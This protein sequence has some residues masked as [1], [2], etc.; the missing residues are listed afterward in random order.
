MCFM[1]IIFNVK[2]L[3]KNKYILLLICVVFSGFVQ[4]Q[5]KKFTLKIK[6]KELGFMSGFGYGIDHNSLPEGN[7]VPVNFSAHIAYK[8]LFLGDSANGREDYFLFM[9]PTYNHVVLKT[10]NGDKEEADAGLTLGF[11]YNYSLLPSLKLSLQL[12]SGPHWYTA[13]TYRQAPGFIFSNFVGLGL[14]QDVAKKLA[15]NFVFRVRHMS[16]ADTRQPN[17]GINTY[18]YMF[19]FVYKLN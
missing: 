15:L 4:A 9:E 2:A 19:G 11:K 14:Y 7:Y 13:T 6:V 1:G 8:S 16:N 5:T 18:N 17:H 10:P 12:A 3:I